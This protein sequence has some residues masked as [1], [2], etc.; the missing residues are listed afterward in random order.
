MMKTYDELMA[1]VNDESRIWIDG[2]LL[3]D[4]GIIYLKSSEEQSAPELRN[5]TVTIPGRHGAYDFGAFME[6]RQFN[7][8]MVFRRQNY[9]NLKQQLRELNA[10]LY[11]EYGR[12]KTVTLR[13]GDEID[14]YYYVRLTGAIVPE[15]TAGRGFIEVPLT[16]FDPHAYAS[17][18]EYDS[19]EDIRYDEGYDYDI[20]LMYDNPKSFKWEYSKH[21]SGV[22]NYSSLATDLM[23][24]I[25]GTVQNG[26]ITNLRNNKKLTLPN[27]NNG[28]LIIDGKR[29]TIIR[30]GNA[31]L[32]GSNY[33]FFDIQPGEVGFLFEGDNP[34][35]T[36][37]Y[38][39]LH[40]FN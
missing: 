12:P 38:K 3:Q 32:E 37:T 28:K 31:I 27:I 34:N 20:G 1:E 26:S 2:E 11:D 24:E 4:D 14:K 8:L 25:Q 15:R 21:Y 40:K 33:N 22:N 18:N 17:A 35:A 10:R 16:A 23:I 19:S 39:W 5:M 7:L 29:F 13:F 6:P 36:V 9:A 30:N